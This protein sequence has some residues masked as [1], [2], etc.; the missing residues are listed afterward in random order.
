MFVIWP[1]KDIKAKKNEKP[2]QS[3]T[4][5]KANLMDI[6]PRDALLFPITWDL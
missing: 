5:R 3:M 2:F 6:L 4:V 1:D